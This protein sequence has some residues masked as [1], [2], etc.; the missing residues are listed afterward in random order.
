MPYTGNS[1]IELQS[2]SL[3]MDITLINQ[4]PDPMIY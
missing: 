4:I 1:V 3:S 2:P